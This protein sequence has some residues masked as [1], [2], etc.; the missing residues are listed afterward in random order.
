V[1]TAPTFYYNAIQGELVWIKPLDQRDM[2]PSRGA[3]DVLV[4]PV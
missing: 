4:R 2:L 1:P 3:V